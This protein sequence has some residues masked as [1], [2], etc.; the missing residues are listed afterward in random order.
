[1]SR[2]FRV[3]HTRRIR[4]NA[5]QHVMQMSTSS[6]SAFS[7]ETVNDNKTILAT[8]NSNPAN[9][10]NAK[11]LDDLNGALDHIA[12]NPM[13][14]HKP[15]IFTSPEESK[16][17]SA[18]M[19][20]KAV[21]QMTEMSETKELF[22]KFEET[23][24]RIATLRH[25]TIAKIHGHAV[26]AGFF[27]G[28]ACDVRCGLDDDNIMISL[29]EMEMG[30]T[31]PSLCYRMILSRIPHA[32]HEILLS[33]PGKHFTPKQ[34]YDDRYFTNLAATKEELM[35]KCIEEADRVHPDSMKAYLSVK[36]YLWR[37]T[38]EDTWNREREQCLQEF[39]E[40]R[41][42]AESHRLV[43]NKLEQMKSKKGK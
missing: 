26:A 12:D 29:P 35:Q 17:F 19:D 34:A 31:F 25:R 21:A 42:S 11:A 16:C 9:F 30:M 27:L 6:G 3:F 33:K 10:L 39:A 28:L 43:A 18:G 24:A 20:L 7:I 23:M 22:G 13:L 40:H 4:C 5:V 1:M 14:K 15:I 38:V 36:D 2:I 32:A 37:S 8:L 41:H